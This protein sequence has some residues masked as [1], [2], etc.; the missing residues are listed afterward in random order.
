MSS[1]RWPRCYV[2]IFLASYIYTYAR[3]IPLWRF[4][5]GI[6]GDCWPVAFSKA[7]ST[8]FYGFSI[9]RTHVATPCSNSFSCVFVALL[10]VD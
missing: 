7:K 10:R 9:V 3:N 1:I 5:A 6:P 2:S 4:I 8:E